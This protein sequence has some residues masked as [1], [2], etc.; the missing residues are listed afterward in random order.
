MHGC[1]GGQSMDHSC[2]TLGENRLYTDEVCQD[3]METLWLAIANRYKN[4]STV[5]A[6]DI[7]NEPQNNSGYEGA[8]SYD[9]WEK[10][11]W[12]L[13]NLIYDRMIKAI[14][15]I[16]D[17][18]V[19]T[20]EGIWRVSNLP[21]P[22]EMGWTNMMY[23][24]HLY[25]D[26]KGFK[27]WAED[28]AKVTKKYGVAG[29]VGEFQ[30]L[31]GLSVC[32]ENSLNWTTWTYKG[33]NNDLGSFFC[34]YGDVER[35]DIINDSFDTIKEKWGEAIETKNFKNKF[36]VTASIKLYSTGYIYTEE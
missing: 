25:D 24:L 4:N 1:P 21:N 22:K 18:H 7:M 29:Y 28:L 15:A 11:S 19:I 10:T 13:S 30:N 3:T 8:N 12:E 17:E 20:V 5:A 34:Y 9:P 14:R 23:Q 32:N 6:Y 27:Q 35:A 2:G 33:T 16:G 26:D 31:S 36:N